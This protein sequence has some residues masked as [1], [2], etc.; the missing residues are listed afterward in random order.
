[1]VFLPAADNAAWCDVVCRSH[2]LATRL[3]PDAWTCTT[4]SPRLYPDAV[5]LD[6]D[7]S[8]ADVLARI[9]VGPG[10]SIKDSFAVLDLHD[11]GF[12]VLFD[13]QWIVREPTVTSQVTDVEWEVVRDPS[14]LEAWE[15]AR[16]DDS[17]RLFLPALLDEPSVT[18]VA[19]RASGRIVCG[20]VLHRGGEVVGVSNVFGDASWPDVLAFAPAATL[21]GYESG[22]ALAEAIEHGFTP[23]GP[24]RV[25]TN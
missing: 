21:V 13:A 25:W 24:L 5:T 10:C 7:A 17:V 23:V 1:M 9:D 16:Q 2:G 15:G 20:A 19:A 6:P 12:R 18:V 14:T 11:H 4:R 8:A 3:E 22:D